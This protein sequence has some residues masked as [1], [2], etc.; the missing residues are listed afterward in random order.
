MVVAHG[1][2][3]Q[4][5]LSGRQRSLPFFPRVLR[6]GEQTKDQRTHETGSS[7]VRNV[8]T[9]AR[10]R[11]GLAS[12]ALR[13]SEFSTHG[14]NYRLV[15]TRIQGA[16]LLK[17]LSRELPRFGVATSHRQAET[18]RLRG[19]HLPMTVADPDRNF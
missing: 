3:A 11:Q 17:R 18:E 1:A 15:A 2:F 4:Q 12:E 7:R 9:R 16:R 5:R 14:E 19:E 6:Q 10:Q 13:Q 8:P